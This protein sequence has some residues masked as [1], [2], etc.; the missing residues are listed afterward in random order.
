[1]CHRCCCVAGKIECTR[2]SVV[3]SE[4]LGLT[5]DVRCR[6]GVGGRVG[7]GGKGWD[8]IGLARADAV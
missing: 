7:E 8:A 6:G 5:G 4:V 2:E 1:M 3:R